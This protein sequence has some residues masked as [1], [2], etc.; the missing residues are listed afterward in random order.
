M[1]ETS[2]AIVK[3]K[4]MRRVSAAELPRHLT[5]DQVYALILAAPKARYKM[6]LMF[7][8]HTGARISEALSVTV[9]DIDWQLKQVRVKTLKRGRPA[10]RMIPLNQDIRGE[11]STYIHTAELKGTDRL[12]P[13]SRFA[14][15]QEIK[16]LAAKATLPPWI[17]AHT[18]R[19]SFAINCLKQGVHIN[20]LREL[21]GH[22]NVENTMVYLK[23][24]QP[25]IHEE[26]QKVKF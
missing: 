6:L 4:A 17:H 12:F 21:L 22:A 14:V 11:L 5:P 18:M 26:L 25:E 3:S 8:W 23:V 19:H 2:L 13:M 10:Q 7:L 16:A 9:E 20:T 24:F 15:H 1:P